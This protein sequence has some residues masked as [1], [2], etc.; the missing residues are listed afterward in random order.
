[1]NTHAPIPEPNIRKN[2][3]LYIR[4]KRYKVLM[5]N[6]FGGKERWVVQD[7]SSGRVTLL[8]NEVAREA[9]IAEA[10]RVEQGYPALPPR[11][12]RRSASAIKPPCI[13]LLESSKNA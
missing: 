1:M 6:D 2:I 13:S 9:K 5:K 10:L 12:K 11:R 7:Q 3:E 8:D 4:G